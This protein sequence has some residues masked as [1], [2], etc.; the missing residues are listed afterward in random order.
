MH[1]TIRASEDQTDFLIRTESGTLGPFQ[2]ET[3]TL[4]ELLCAVER[5]TTLSIALIIGEPLQNE[6]L[7]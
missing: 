4:A 2:I 6:S 3:N 7:E 5:S 1:L